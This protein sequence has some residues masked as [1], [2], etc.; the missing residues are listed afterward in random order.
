MLL[1]AR[2][3]HFPKYFQER[4]IDNVYVNFPDPWSKK[5]WKKHRLLSDEFLQSIS[6]SLVNSGA[7]LYKTD[8]RE[9]FEATLKLLQQASYFDLTAYSFDL[10]NSE[11]LSGNIKTE[12]EKLFLSKGQ[13]IH[14]LRAISS[15]KVSFA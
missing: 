1:R 7:F 4:K 11:Y 15:Q 3:E 12:F 8:H 5:K 13:P 6:K 2:A 14:Y 10:Y 9:Y